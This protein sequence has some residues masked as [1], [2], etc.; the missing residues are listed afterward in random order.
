[1]NILNKFNWEKFLYNV[2]LT[3]GPINQTHFRM[4]YPLK[5]DGTPKDMTAH[6]KP[7]AFQLVKE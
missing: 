4:K 7:T 1:V 6:R 5:L 3:G 2:F